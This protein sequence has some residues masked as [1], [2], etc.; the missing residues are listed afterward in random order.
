MTKSSRLFLF[1]DVNVW[2]ALTYERHIHHIVA[3]EWFFS[4]PAASRIFFCRLTQLGLLRLLNEPAVMGVDRALGQQ[5]AWR[6]Y[7][8]WLEDSR[9]EFLHEPMGLEDLFRSFT[10]STQASPKEWAD[11]YLMAFAQASRLTIV[12]FDRAL[13]AKAKDT[14]LLRA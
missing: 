1:P 7:D 9:I 11:S 8:R 2:V 4:L 3:R 12:T 13:N 5:E 14:I 10:S 6:T